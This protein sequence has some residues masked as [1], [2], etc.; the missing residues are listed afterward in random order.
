MPPDINE[1]KPTQPR[2]E[3]YSRRQF[4]DRLRSFDPSWFENRE[5]LEYSVLWDSC[6]CFP[7]RIFDLK[8][9]NYPFTSGGYSNWKQALTTEKGFEAH[10]RSKTHEHAYS[11]WLEKGKRETSGRQIE[12]SWNIK[13]LGDD[14]LK[15]LNAV[16]LV[17]RFLSS[18]GLPFRGDSE[19][20]C[21]MCGKRY[22]V[23]YI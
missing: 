13:K 5:W 23:G 18:N 19:C 20:P 7:C 15:W 8:N 21:Y 14:H 16:F 12:N 10:K 6:F 2:L 3:T 9:K 11:S 4:G 22:L 1:E 17:T